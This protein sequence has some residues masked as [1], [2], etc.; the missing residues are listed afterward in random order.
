MF[1]FLQHNN[2]NSSLFLAIVS[3]FSTLVQDL[4]NWFCMVSTVDTFVVQ[5]QVRFS[6]FVAMYCITASKRQTTV[7]SS[8]HN[9][10]TVYLL[11]C[12]VK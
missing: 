10:L 7:F 6:I 2:C 3:Y 4:D 5:R 12:C 8:F 9:S 1:K 11:C